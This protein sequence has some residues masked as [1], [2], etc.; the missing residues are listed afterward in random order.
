MAGAARL[1]SP[2]GTLQARLGAILRPRDD[3][4]AAGRLGFVEHHDRRS[5]R[6]E[7]IAMATP[8]ELNGPACRPPGRA[9]GIPG[10]GFALETVGALD[11]ENRV[12][13]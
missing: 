1:R 6:G 12:R 7:F 3:C 4:Q 9:Q 5:V 10:L 13:A 8:R 11:P 2:S